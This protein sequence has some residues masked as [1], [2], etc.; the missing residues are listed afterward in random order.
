MEE[1]KPEDKPPE[2]EPAPT[3]D[4]RDADG[5]PI[6]REPTLDDVRGT[7]GSGLRI[8]VGCTA[9][10]VLLVLGFWVLRALVLR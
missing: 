6:H 3:P 7:E 10:V 8:A 4:A 2:P 5:L 1:T 9:L